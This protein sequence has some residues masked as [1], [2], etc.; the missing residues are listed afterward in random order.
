MPE[1]VTVDDLAIAAEWLRSYAGQDEHDTEAESMRKVADYLVREVYRRDE[2]AL[3]R[4]VQRANPS[5]SAR[6]ARVYARARAA[7]EIGPVRG[8]Q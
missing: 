7:K 3:A 8:G 1:Q 4:A 6:T 2:Q 5:M